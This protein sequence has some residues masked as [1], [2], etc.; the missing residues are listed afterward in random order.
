MSDEK[1]ETEQVS[2]RVKRSV[3]ARLERIGQQAKPFAVK[4]NAVIAAALEEYADA[5]D[6]PV[7]G[8]GGK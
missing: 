2:I 3:L 6:Q 8:K 4:R 1:D 5:N 7:K